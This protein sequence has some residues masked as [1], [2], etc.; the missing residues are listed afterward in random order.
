MGSA[1][2]LVVAAAVVLRPDH[3]NSTTTATATSTS[4]STGRGTTHPARTT[5]TVGPSRTTN[6]VTFTAVGDTGLGKPG[7]LPADP[8]TYLSPIQAPWPPPSCSATSRAPSP[9]PPARSATTGSTNCFAFRVPTDRRP[10][11]APGSDSPSSTAPTTTPTTSASQGADDTSAALAAAG[12]AQTGLP[13]QIAVV[14]DGDT[15]VAFV[16]FAPYRNTNNMLDFAT[17]KAL[18]AKARTR[19]MWSSSTCT[20]APKAPAPPT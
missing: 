19:P 1:V 13:G 11:T 17:A 3:H 8:L 7:Q 10:D 12:I 6:P 5:T 16:G 2:V 20:P 15:K 18:I 4:T 9:P 14:S